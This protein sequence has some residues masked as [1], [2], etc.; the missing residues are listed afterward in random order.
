MRRP[1]L[2]LLPERMGTALAHEP[3]P[4][5]PGR[6][7]TTCGVAG[8]GSIEC[9]GGM[10]QQAINAPRQLRPP[11]ACAAACAG[12]ATTE[13]LCGQCCCP[14]LPAAALA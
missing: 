14:Q 10:Q 12:R 1:V 6:K 9:T 7:R 2:L 11:A 5:S 3:Q 13:L 8:P 4:A